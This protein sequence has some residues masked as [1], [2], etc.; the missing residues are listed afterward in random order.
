M[1]RTMQLIQ[2]GI[3]DGFFAIQVSLRGWKWSNNTRKKLEALRPRA[4]STFP[5]KMSLQTT[6]LNPGKS[7]AESIPDIL[8]HLKAYIAIA[9][10]VQGT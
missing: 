9:F 3:R 10:A 5:L 2:T 1:L 7:R 8:S 6:E 4:L